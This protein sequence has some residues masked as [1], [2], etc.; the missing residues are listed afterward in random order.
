MGE[1]ASLD[2]FVGSGDDGDDDAGDTD[3]S[4]ASDA[5]AVDKE[6]ASEDAD[7]ETATAS[8][9]DPTP[10]TTTYAWSDEGTQC[11]SCGEVVERRWQQ[12]GSL[13]CVDC[14]EWDRA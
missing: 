11:A 12:D 10:A 5:T 6:A 1:D 8:E 14:K 9:G 4:D 13:V 2:Q 7:T 3:A